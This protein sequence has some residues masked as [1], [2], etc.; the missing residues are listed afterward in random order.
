VLAVPDQDD[1]GNYI[2][3]DE[4][5][6]NLQL[7]RICQPAQKNKVILDIFTIM[8]Y[9]MEGILDTA[10][11][12]NIWDCIL[13]SLSNSNVTADLILSPIKY[14]K[15]SYIVQNP[16][17]AQDFKV[18]GH[19]GDE[20]WKRMDYEGSKGD[21]NIILLSEE[22]IGKTLTMYNMDL[23][24]EYDHA[25]IHN[26][27]TWTSI[28]RAITDSLPDCFFRQLQVVME[29]K[30]LTKAMMKYS[31]EMVPYPDHST[32]SSSST[33]RV[34]PQWVP[35]PELWTDLKGNPL[36]SGPKPGDI[37]KY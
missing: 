35:T 34:T 33:A 8:A 18:P 26:A 29:T 10:N 4:E 2:P 11:I 37:R 21:S 36:T 3:T 1:Q 27:D 19:P 15:V 31:N 5:N 6:M 7:M 24:P 30:T 17:D 9:C 20:D 25:V 22:H 32:P 16:R 12:M 28:L 13:H 14:A 23:V